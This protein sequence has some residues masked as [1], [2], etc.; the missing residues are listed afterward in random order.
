MIVVDASFLTD[1]LLSRAAT[2]EAIEHALGGRGHTPLHAPELVEPEALNALRRVARRGAISD[3]RAGEAVADMGTIRLIRHP[4]AP[5]RE[6]IWQL[7]H[8]LTAHD[9]AYLALAEALPDPILMT[10]DAGLA[11]LAA[12]ALGS[13]RVGYVE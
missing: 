1:L 5:L 6:R 12:A 8:S 7:R 9:A 2:V 3:R 13:D 4:H 11:A 10:S